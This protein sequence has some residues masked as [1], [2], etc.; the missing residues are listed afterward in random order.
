MYKIKAEIIII[1][2]KEDE[3][4]LNML[5]HIKEELELSEPEKIN[6]LPKWD[7][8]TYELYF[9]KNR[10]ICL[11]IIPGS[12]IAT[13]YFKDYLEANLVIFASKHSSKTGKKTLLAHPLG[14][15]AEKFQNSGLNRNLGIAPAYAIYKALK[16]LKLY[17]EKLGLDQY[18]VGLEV[19]HHGPTELSVPAIFME[20]GGNIEAWR[21]KLATRAVALAILAVAKIYIKPSFEEKLIT[22]IGVGGGHYAPSFIK[23]VQRDEIMVG[24]MIP[25]FHSGKLDKEMI[26]KAFNKTEGKTKRFLI[27][28]KG[29]KASDRH[30]IISLI[31]ELGLE[32]KL[33]SDYLF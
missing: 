27:D 24:H 5:K 23:R 14:N 13:D 21:D 19:T 7:P 11:L 18:W 4:S 10:S 8:G 15:W 22:Y 26:E 12:Q 32:Y 16:F 17:Q 3:A 1:F 29:L 31:D 9:T 6:C 2:S 28:K 30:R 25:K 33:T 20:A